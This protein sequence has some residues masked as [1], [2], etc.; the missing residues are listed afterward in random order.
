MPPVNLFEVIRDVRRRLDENGRVSQR[1]LRKQVTE[2]FT[3]AKGS[4]Y[5]RQPPCALAMRLL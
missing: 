2:L 3:D 5:P 1:L 4:I